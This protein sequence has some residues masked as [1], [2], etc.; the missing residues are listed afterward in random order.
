MLKTTQDFLD[1]EVLVLA[2]YAIK[3]IETKGRKYKEFPHS[4]RTDFQRDRDRIVHCRAFRRLEYKTQVFLNGAG[5]HYR[6]RL[7][8]TIE[9]AAISRV[10]ELGEQGGGGAEVGFESQL[11][12]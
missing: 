3:S 1:H 6:T 10:C 9:V 2:S 11:C 8:H 7:T 5:D 4:I 12:V